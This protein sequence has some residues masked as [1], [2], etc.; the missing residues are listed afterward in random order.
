[1]EAQTFNL[2]H[3]EMTFQVKAIESVITKVQERKDDYEQDPRFAESLAYQLHNLYCAFEDLFRIVAKF[4]E[5]NIE[6]EARFHIQLLKRMA[7]DIK[8]VRPALI[9]YEL[10]RSLDELRAFRHA[11]R[12]AY[13]YDID[14]DKLSLVLTQYEYVEANY[15]Q[16][17]QH[18][19]QILQED[20]T[21]PLEEEE[22]KVISQ[23][24]KKHK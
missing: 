1:M 4:F 16:E 22:R 9:S 23:E 20:S 11:F 24:L 5:N 2:L 8:G 12:H 17:I 3:A 19:L 18:F 6:D 7:L 21:D 13:S 10:F 14:T 15:T